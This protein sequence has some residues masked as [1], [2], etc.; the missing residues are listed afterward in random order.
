MIFLHIT[1]VCHP[2]SFSSDL[3]SLLL[4]DLNSLD[5]T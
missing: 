4:I 1:I 2:N 5:L 3:K